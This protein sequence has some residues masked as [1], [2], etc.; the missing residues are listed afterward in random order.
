VEQAYAD[1]RRTQRLEIAPEERHQILWLAADLPAIWAAA[2][3]THADRKRFLWLLVKQVALTPVD[4]PLRQTQVQV[5]W[6]TE[7]VTILTVPRLSRKER[8]RTPADVI[9]TIATLAPTHTNAAIAALLNAR[10]LRSGKG[11]AFTATAVVWVRRKYDIT[12]P[13]LDPRHAACLEACPDGRYSTRALASQL[14]VT[15][16][17]VSWDHLSPLGQDRATTPTSTRCDR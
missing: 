3:T 5:L 13:L 1:A 8:T 16:Q 15:I 17:V 4:T 14:G 7:V 9:S 6:H 10:G 12:K 11:H 2:T